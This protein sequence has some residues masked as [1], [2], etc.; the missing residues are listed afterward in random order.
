MLEVDEGAEDNAAWSSDLG[1]EDATNQ[2]QAQRGGAG[3][4]VARERAEKGGE[5]DREFTFGLAEF[6]CLR[7]LQVRSR[8]SFYRALKLLQAEV[9]L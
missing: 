1:G 8:S 3:L 7:T 6:Q 2:M 9:P 5:R 4:S